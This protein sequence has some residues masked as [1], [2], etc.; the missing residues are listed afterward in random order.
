MISLTEISSV[1]G[2]P[3]DLLTNKR[4]CSD[5]KCAEFSRTKKR[6]QK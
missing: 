3:D 1:R 2:S 5:G 4:R 6:W